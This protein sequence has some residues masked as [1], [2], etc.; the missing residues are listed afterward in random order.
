MNY[1]EN[2]PKMSGGDTFT[3]EILLYLPVRFYTRSCAL[4]VSLFNLIYLGVHIIYYI[5]YILYLS[6]YFTYTL[7]II[8]AYFVSLLHHAYR[9]YEYIWITLLQF[10]GFKLVMDCDDIK[11]GG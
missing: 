6:L 8:L 7:F 4:F 3:S 9:N 2:V 5:L 11:A 1:V 10:A